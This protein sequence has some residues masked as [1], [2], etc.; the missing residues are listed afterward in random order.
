MKILK[1]KF[2]STFEGSTS[3]WQKVN[4]FTNN[5]PPAV[6]PQRLGNYPG[7][8]HPPDPV[9]LFVEKKLTALSSSSH[10]GSEKWWQEIWATT[11]CFCFGKNDDGILNEVTSMSFEQS[12]RLWENCASKVNAYCNEKSIPPFKFF[13]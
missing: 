4:L 5:G 3:W 10:L 1:C 2:L 7:C 8:L 6:F 9:D 12:P 11:I 13:F